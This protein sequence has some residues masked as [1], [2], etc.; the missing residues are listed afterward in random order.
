M[1]LATA[2]VLTAL[3][4]VVHRIALT[5]EELE[6]LEER[7]N[8]L[9]P[10]VWRHTK[11][12]LELADRGGRLQIGF[13]PL[14]FPWL[15]LA[16]ERDFVERYGATIDL[17]FELDRGSLFAAAL[18]LEQGHGPRSETLQLPLSHAWSARAARLMDELPDVGESVLLTLERALDGC[19]WDPEWVRP[20]FE[21]IVHVADMLGDT[22]RVGR[23]RTMLQTID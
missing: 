19:P 18:S 23:A 21:A 20:L 14:L 8:L 6:V 7:G 10:E 9:S 2:H 3:Y 11:D 5:P 1:E 15:G 16:N 4:A 13:V 22:E 17:A 12:M